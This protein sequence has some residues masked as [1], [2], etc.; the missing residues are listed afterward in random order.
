MKHALFI[1]SL[2]TERDLED[3]H[4]RLGFSEIL[5]S[6]FNKNDNETLMNHL[7]QTKIFF[8]FH[9]KKSLNIL[10]WFFVLA[11]FILVFWWRLR[12]PGSNI[13]TRME[14]FKIVARL[15]TQAISKYYPHLYCWYSIFNL[16]TFFGCFL[17]SLRLPR[18][19]RWTN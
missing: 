12:I 4:S 14:F 19:H 15:C 17:E 3:L 5:N 2:L 7:Q 8:S 11:F 9:K 6:L 1:L 10:G 13:K 16:K 18:E